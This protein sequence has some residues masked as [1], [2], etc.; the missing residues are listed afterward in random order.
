ML[1]LPS[2]LLAVWLLVVTSPVARASSLIGS[3]QTDTNTECGRYCL[4]TPNCTA[5][6]FNAE[7]S[8]CNLYADSRF[9]EGAV[10]GFSYYTNIRTGICLEPE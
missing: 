1:R 6:A 3:T 8:G 10:K 7:S 9:V 2:L 5:F 4:D